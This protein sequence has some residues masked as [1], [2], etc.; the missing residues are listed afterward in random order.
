[1]SPPQDQGNL[2]HAAGNASKDE[3]AAQKCADALSLNTYL[4]AKPSVTERLVSGVKISKSEKKVDMRDFLDTLS[5]E[6][7]G[8]LAGAENLKIDDENAH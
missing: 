1:M 3:K 8:D 5:E 2:N 4:Y 7:D 6:V